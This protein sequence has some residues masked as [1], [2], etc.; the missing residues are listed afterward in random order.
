MTRTVVHGIALGSLI[1]LGACARDVS[2]SKE[3]DP[4]E[5]GFPVGDQVFPAIASVTEYATWGVDQHGGTV[6]RSA[7]ADLS[8]G[9][10]GRVPGRASVEI[11]VGLRGR[12]DHR[13]VVLPDGR[14]SIRPDL[15]PG[16]VDV[17]ELL[18]PAGAHL[19]LHR[20]YDSPGPDV[21]YILSEAE[22]DRLVLWQQMAQE[23]TEIVPVGDKTLVRVEGRGINRLHFVDDDGSLRSSD[24]GTAYLNVADLVNI[25]GQGWQVLRFARISEVE[26]ADKDPSIDLRQARTRKHATFVVCAERMDVAGKDLAQLHATLIDD[27]PEFASCATR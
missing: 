3:G 19:A 6:Q 8:L 18:P 13:P 20:S 4:A 7:D 27:V 26:G 23:P 21:D 14:P 15:P 17:L 25:P 9:Y 2:H 11:S 16:T 10:A 22:H 12:R 24:L 1:A 5:P